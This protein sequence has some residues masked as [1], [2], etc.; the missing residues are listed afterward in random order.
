MK[1]KLLKTFDLNVIPLAY[2]FCF[3]GIFCIAWLVMA[4]C[5]YPFNIAKIIRYNSV[6]ICSLICV[7]LIYSGYRKYGRSAFIGLSW[8]LILFWL[9]VLCRMVTESILYSTRPI[10]SALLCLFFPIM[11]LAFSIPISKKIAERSFYILFISYALIVILMIF[12]WYDWILAGDTLRIPKFHLDETKILNCLWNQSSGLYPLRIGLIGGLLALLSLWGFITHKIH[13]L[14]FISLYILGTVF[15]YFTVFKYMFIAW[16]ISHLYI[17]YICYL[18]RR[19]ILLI[20]IPFLIAVN[21]VLFLQ[22]GR[23][24]TG[25]VTRISQFYKIINTTTTTATT[26]TTIIPPNNTPQSGGNIQPS[27]NNTSSIDNTNKTGQMSFI[28]KINSTI[29][30]MVHEQVL[31]PNTYAVKLHYKDKNSQF[32]SRDDIWEMYCRTGM[33]SRLFMYFMTYYLL[34]EHPIT[35]YGRHIIMNFGDHYSFFTPHANTA[36]AFLG[37]GLIGGTLFLITIIIG[38]YDSWIIIKKC[39]DYCWIAIIFIFGFLSQDVQLFDLPVIWLPLAALHAC[40]KFIVMDR[41][42]QI[43]NIKS[44]I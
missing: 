18:G 14:L 9:F 17:L 27:T 8:S 19:R 10:V 5:N 11:I 29:N 4:V 3:E 42:K 26:I 30:K 28:D 34:K 37:T 32:T 6:V 44:V 22:I 41:V 40:T 23:T 12:N 16:I 43:N 20:L 31:Q 39:P 24:G 15:I 21:V 38:F 1:N 7:Y 35:G 33:D 36:S 25:Y 2:F 13:F